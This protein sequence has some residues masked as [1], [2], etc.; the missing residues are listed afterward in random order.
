MT[1]FDSNRPIPHLPRCLLLRTHIWEEILQKLLQRI[2]LRIEDELLPIRAPKGKQ[3]IAVIRPAGVQEFQICALDWLWHV[4]L[5]AFLALRPAFTE[6]PP[7]GKD[8]RC[9]TLDAPVDSHHKRGDALH[10]PRRVEDKSRAALHLTVCPKD[11]RCDAL[12]RRNPKDKRCE[13]L[14]EPVNSEDKVSIPLLQAVD[15]KDER[16]VTGNVCHY[17]KLKRL[18]YARRPLTYN[19][20]SHTRHKQFVSLTVYQFAS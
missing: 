4:V 10:P 18:A 5:L 19:L 1:V 3:R 20:Q 17:A 6:L 13:T 2:L 16:R 9:L 14:D 12:P 8:E 15:P 11:K 7:D